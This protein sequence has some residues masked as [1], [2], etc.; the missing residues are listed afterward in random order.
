MV[1]VLDAH[2]KHIGTFALHFSV[3]STVQTGISIF[4]FAIKAMEILVD[5]H[6]ESGYR[7]LAIKATDT[8][9]FWFYFIHWS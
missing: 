4:V 9:L 8:W 3:S 7:A 6:R 2:Y 5:V 1:F